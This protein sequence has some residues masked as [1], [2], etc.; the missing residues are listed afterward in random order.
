MSEDRLVLGVDTSAYT[1]SVA[2]V[3]V[4]GRLVSDRRQVLAVP[5]GRRGLRQSDAVFQHVTRLPEL[6]EAAVADAAVWLAA[7]AGAASPGGGALPLAAVAASVAPRSRPDSYMPVFRAGAGF[8]RALAAWHG[9]PF[10][11]VSHQDGHIWAGL[12][13][14]APGGTEADGAAAALWRDVDDVVVLH[15]SGGTTELLRARRTRRAGDGPEEPFASARW[16]VESLAA[17]EDLYAGQFIDR[18]GVRLGLPFPAGPHLERLAAEGD[19]AAAPLPVAVRGHRLSFSGPDTA[20]ARL[21]ER[22]VA[23]ADVAAAVQE[24]V[25][26]SLSRWA[27][28]VLAEGAPALFLGVGGVMA[29]QA[30]RRRLSETLSPLG[31]RCVFAAPRCSV[32]NAIGVALA[33]AVWLG[34]PGEQR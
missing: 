9:V 13:S 18:A 27:A 5:A 29:N 1:T 25:A 17:S 23:A 21:T 7:S 22:G 6:L 10:I 28:Q 24:C 3:T 11:D 2:V 4:D 19:P 26:A 32:D 15:A 12:W 20:A 30:L 33:G 34:S 14:A 8:A 31:V 16:I